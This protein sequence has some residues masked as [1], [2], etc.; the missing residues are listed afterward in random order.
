MKYTRKACPL[1]VPLVEEGWWDNE[2]A[3]KVAIEYLTPLLK[4]DID[5]AVLGCTHYPLLHKTISRVMGDNVKL[6]SSAL[7][8]AKVVKQFIT[9]FDMLRDKYSPCL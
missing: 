2:I 9:E 5:T 8:I 7:E 1:F 4:E 6:V 3:H